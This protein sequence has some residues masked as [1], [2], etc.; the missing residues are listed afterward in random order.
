MQV[1]RWFRRPCLLL[2]VEFD[3][4][5]SA[6]CQDGAPFS[7]IPVE[8]KDGVSRRK[9]QDIAEIMTL[10]LFELDARTHLQRGVEKEAWR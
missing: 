6:G 2:D 7:I 8:N 10:L 9:S 3:R 4:L 5:A 1:V